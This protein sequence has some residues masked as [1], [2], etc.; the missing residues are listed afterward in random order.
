MYR[1]CQPKAIP[2]NPAQAVDI[3]PGCGRS[4]NKA[5]KDEC[6]ESAAQL[7]GNPFF[8][9]VRSICACSSKAAPEIGDEKFVFYDENPD[10]SSGSFVKNI[11]H[12]T[13]HRDFNYRDEPA[14]TIAKFHAPADISGKA[15]D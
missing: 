12:R 7:S 6:V 11:A 9:I 10:L 4:G 5:V 13:S 15:S 14:V 3:I 1:T 2:A 8:S